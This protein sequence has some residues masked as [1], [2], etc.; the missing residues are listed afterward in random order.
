MFNNLN[1][2]ANIGKISEKSK[3]YLE[4]FRKKRFVLAWKANNTFYPRIIL[5]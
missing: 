4:I 2:K 1:L 5:S 3:H